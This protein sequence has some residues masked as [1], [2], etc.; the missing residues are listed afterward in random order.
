M[1]MLRGLLLGIDKLDHD[2]G[3]ACL[4]DAIARLEGKR[5]LI[6]LLTIV[7]SDR[8][9]LEHA[10]SLLQAGDIPTQDLI[11]LSYGRGLDHLPTDD[12]D[13]LMQALEGHGGDGIWSAMEIAQMYQH[14]E[15][16][17]PAH[18]RRVASLLVSPDLVASED[19]SS[20]R[21]TFTRVCSKASVPR[22]ES[23][24]P[25]RKVCPVKS[26][27]WRSTTITCIG[28]ISTA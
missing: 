23:M 24:S 16:K 13:F 7:R 1:A 6:D 4:A 3:S 10:V 14:G 15:P 25:S 2:L 18:A 20:V 27:D 17:P 19:E 22:S 28:G 11:L 21:L 8:Q 26:S 12:I 9:R 5:P